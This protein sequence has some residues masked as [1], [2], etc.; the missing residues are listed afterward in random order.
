MQLTQAAQL[1]RELLRAQQA[2]PENTIYFLDTSYKEQP[3]SN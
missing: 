2:M 1:D 3:R